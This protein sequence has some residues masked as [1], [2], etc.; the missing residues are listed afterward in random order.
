M[1]K[2]DYKLD[3]PV[4]YSLSELH[5]EYS[6]DY[7]GM[8]FYHPDFCPFGSM[9]AIENSSKYIVEYSK[10]IDNFFVV[11]EKPELSSRLELKNELVCLQMISKDKI[12]TETTGDFTLLSNQHADALFQLVTL[13]QPGYFKKKTSLLG[14]YFG[15]FKNGQ[16]VSVTGERMQ[17]NDFVEVSAIVTHP[18]HT[19][20]GYARQLIA[21]TVNRIVDQGKTPYLHV[22]ET[23]YGAIKLYERLGFVVRRKISFWNITTSELHP[24]A[25][26]G[27]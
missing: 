13:V 27:I 20:Q 9:K 16:L 7:N 2:T 8:K 6:I 17:M 15:I 26:L 11:G 22:A 12:V 24:A 19:G 25:G 18:D 1:K 5:K 21:H 23:N 10:L 4:W 3:N 14:N